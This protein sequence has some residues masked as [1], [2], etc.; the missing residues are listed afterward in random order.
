MG[1]WD[2]I[3]VL[4]ENTEYLPSGISLWEFGS[5]R[6]PKQKAEE[7]YQKR[8]NDPLGYDPKESTYIFVSPRIWKNA[9]EWAWEKSKEGIWKDVRVITGLELEEWIEL[10]PT[11]AIWLAKHIGKYLPFGIQSPEIFW[12]EWSTGPNF[13][14]SAEILLGGRN[15]EKVKIIN[16][17]ERP[18]II[19]V[20]GISK[21]ESLAFIISCFLYESEKKEDFF[22]KSVIVDDHENLRS[23]IY[24]SKPLYLI[25]RFELENTSILNKAI[26]LGHTIFLPLSI[27]SLYNGQ[28][29]IILPKIDREEF[30]K[31]LS[32]LGISREL[33]EVHSKESARNI[34]ILRRRLAFEKATPV[35][36]KVENIEDLAPAILVGRWDENVIGDQEVISKIAGLP[37]SEF[38]KKINKWRFSQDSPITKIGRTWQLTS[39]FDVWVNASRNLTQTDFISLEKAAKTILSEIHPRFELESNQRLYA[40]LHNKRSNFSR[41]I[42]DGVLQS[43]ILTSVLGKK[44]DLDLPMSAELWVDRIISNILKPENPNLWKSIAGELPLFAEASPISFLDVIDQQ[45]SQKNSPIMALFEEEP[46]LIV[47]RSFHPSLLWALEGLAWLPEYFP[48]SVMLLGNL[49][50][51]DPGGNISNRPI[52][53]LAEIFKPWHYQTLA[54]YAQR[55]EVLKQLSRKYPEIAWN[56]LTRMLPGPSYGTAIPTHQMRWRLDGN[57]SSRL[58][59]KSEIIQTHSEVIDHLI[60]NF[61]YS[62]N[63]LI[64][65]LKLSPQLDSE[66]RIKLLSFIA[67]IYE[68]TPCEGDQPWD[69]I[70]SILHFQY[71]YRDSEISIPFSELKLYEQLYILMEPKDIIN[72]NIWVFEENWPL[73]KEGGHRD[74]EYHKKIHEKRIEAFSNIFSSF[75]LDKIIELGNSVKKAYSF[76]S[77]AANFIESEEDIRIF[78]SRIFNED[79]QELF[80]YGFIVKKSIDL[81]VGWVFQLYDDLK[82]TEIPSSVLVHLFLPLKQSKRLW[83]FIEQ[84]DI[85]L[86]QYYWDEVDPQFWDLQIETKIIGIEQLLKHQRYLST[87]EI[88]SR[89]RKE[90]PTPL[91]LRALEYAITRQSKE[92]TSVYFPHTLML[93]FEELDTRKDAD[94]ETRVKLEWLYLPFLTSVFNNQSPKLLHEELSTNPAF[95]VEVLKWVYKPDNEEFS[96]KEQNE[97]SEELIAKRMKA[98][99][100]LFNSWKRV[101][102][103]SYDNEIDIDLL[104]EWVFHVRTLAREI[105][106]LEM[107]DLE[108]GKLFAQFPEKSQPWPPKEI[109][110][111]LEEV[112]SKK[113]MQSFSIAI[114]NKHGF[115]SRGPYDGGKIERAHSNFFRKQSTTYQM[116]YPSVSMVLAKIAMAFEEDAKEMDNEAERRSLEN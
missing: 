18:G 16:Q 66:S 26:E 33:A 40:N 50:T 42:R 71:S 22:S 107:A 3:L 39:S 30:I 12:D 44:M 1:G 88:C 2:G 73:L 7:D 23:L 95:F 82:S 90:F 91:I 79:F 19:P 70:R 13:N 34:T 58:Y 97:L 49:A 48:Q 85:S 67:K 75:G 63:K 21:E 98:G 87:L 17:S 24:Q 76:G 55:F 113:I 112:N 103:S 41:R 5:T 15:N 43:L 116:K 52:N 37:Y 80:F 14:L 61:D 28:D 54:T 89:Y 56:V 83:G 78:C 36:A 94:R 84:A 64:E 77:T 25:I 20:E 81:G 100:D 45:L 96:E 72:R 65:L 99:F 6:R 8:T 68:E 74:N 111:I 92:K 106:R 32:S 93:I 102:G 69:E 46:G 62:E 109:C 105:H 59:Y 38:V 60:L 57:E 47:K 9:D 86:W 27:E 108:I 35:W 29:K 11:V 104:K 110:Q 4:K 10:A 51:K 114:R 31:A 53:S 115:T 101:P